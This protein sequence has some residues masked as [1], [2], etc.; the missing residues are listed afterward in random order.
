MVLL[1]GSTLY[2]TQRQ[3]E[4]HEIR[5]IGNDLKQIKLQFQ[6]S[7]EHQQ[8][9]TLKL[10]QTITLD[11][12]FRSFLNNVKEN[13]FPFT[14]EIAEDTGGEMVFMVDEYHDL[15]AVFPANEKM[16]E[17]YQR[18][19]ETFPLAQVIDQG[20][21]FAH[22]LSL[23]SGLF[24]VVYVPLK[25]SLS[26]DFARGA[27]VVCDRIDNAWARHIL[28]P[29]KE[30]VE[31]RAAFFSDG[32]F[33]AGDAT[34]DLAKSGRNVSLQSPDGTGV[35]EYLGERYLVRKG[36]LGHDTADYVLL[37]SLD[38]ALAPFK[39]LRRDILITGGALLF[40]G[41]GFTLA[42]ARRVVHPLQLLVNGTRNILAGEY[43][44]HID[45]R[46]K[47]EVGQ[48][49]N[50]FNGMVDGLREKE[51]I[52]ESFGKYLHPKIV[53]QIL[54]NPEKLKLGGTRQVQTV[55]FSDIADFTRF[56]EK[57]S[58]D[59][60]IRLLNEYLGAMTEEVTRQEGIID[61][62]IGDAIMAFWNPEFSHGDHA[63]LACQT[64][65]HMQKRLTLLRP[66]WIADGQ[67][68][69]RIRIGLATGEMIV[70]NLGSEHAR[71]YTCIGDTVNYGSRLEALN[72]EYGTRILI[73]KT[74]HDLARLA[75]VAREI[76]L[77]R[78]KGREQSSPIYE[79]MG[80]EKESTQ[81]Q[82]QLID[83]YGQALVAYRQGAFAVAGDLFA[84]IHNRFP[85]D[86]PSHI[87]SK[88]CLHYRQH[89]PHD[90]TGIHIL[91]AK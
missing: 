21:D 70:G 34:P 53:T 71:N 17:W 29:K 87:M 5:R 66:R 54:E 52:R 81:E 31:I 90:W 30:T 38:R 40:I 85:Y 22:V 73:D 28:D 63:V 60:L 33:T 57:M 64:A 91:T 13:F 61:K 42:F 19:K 12:K 32:R 43:D 80:L 68:E 51:H 74:T 44:F 37:A 65:I 88:R 15:R 89:P 59:A 45:C 36:V 26:D 55:L 46:S 4:D 75:I 72:K 6:D 39:N 8:E 3:A 76:D 86:Q 58:P 48:L 24:N 67:P 9:H 41:L 69:V 18:H 49:A 27:I 1:L 11:Q 50:A 47:D 16:R 23:D 2:L 14:E 77:V 62:Y 84:A 82:Q 35:F 20:R 78:V 56:S 10:V 79:L 83:G 7:L 25:E